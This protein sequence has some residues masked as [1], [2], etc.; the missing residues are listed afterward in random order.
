MTPLRQRMIEDMQLSG[1]SPHTQ[2]TYVSAVRQL[3]AYYMRSPDEIS[4]EELRE[5]FL[6]LVNVNQFAR[7]TSGYL[8]LPMRKGNRIYEGPM[9][10]QAVWDIVEK[11]APVEK[12]VPHDLRRTFAK[13][14]YKAGA[15]IEQ[16]QKSLGHASI[17]TTEDYIG[18][19]LDL[20]QAPSDLIRLEL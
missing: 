1:K 9:T 13:L 3:A 4:E 11:Y 8:F 6:Y 19:D 20:K 2:R 5:Y 7:T 17:K 10:S 16:I 12:L 15:P 14:A 18:V